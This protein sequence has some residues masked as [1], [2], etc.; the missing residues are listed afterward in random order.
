MCPQVMHGLA[1]RYEAFHK[2]AYTPAA[3]S[4]AITLSHRYIQ[5]RYLP[6]KAIDLMDEAGSQA[7]MAAYHARKADTE[8]Y[9]MRLEELRQVRLSP[10][11]AFF[12]ARSTCTRAGTHVCA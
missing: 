10:P 8:D 12:G 6:D 11:R 2:V 5:D 7:R 4:A 3:L 1:S 9:S